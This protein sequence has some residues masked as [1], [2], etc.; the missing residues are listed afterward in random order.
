MLPFCSCS[1]GITSIRRTRLSGLQDW[2]RSNALK[3]KLAFFGVAAAA[4]SLPL[5][6]WMRLSAGPIFGFWQGLLIVS[7]AST[8]GATLAF[9]ASWYLLR[10]R[11]REK[12]GARAAA[13]DEGLRRDTRFFLFS[14]GLVT[15][16]PFFAVNLLMGLTPSVERCTDLWVEVL[17]GYSKLT[18]PW[19]IEAV[20][21]AA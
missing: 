7:F 12:L 20:I 10:D 18:D 11:V 19:R 4:L 21:A 3:L 17:E 14:L 6:V 5:A 16:T 13:I 1:E 15:V 2:Q 9:L 8:I